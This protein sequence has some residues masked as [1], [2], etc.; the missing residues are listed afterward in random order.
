M[1]QS[2][3]ASWI[4]TIANTAAGFGLSLFLQWVYFDWWLGFPLHI[5]DN[6]VF[7]VIMTIVSLARG[8]T[9]RR[10]FEA[11]HIR[12]PLSPFMQ[13]VIAERVRQ[14]EQEG[15][16]VEHDNA[17]DAGT[18]AHAGASYALQADIWEKFPDTVRSAPPLCPGSWPWARSWWKP[19]EFRRDLVKAAALIIA[20]GERH[21]RLKTKGRA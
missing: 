3:L 2:R 16:S 12:R 5:A 14:I 13:A 17:H 4:E 1:K 20:D 21:D 7:A 18:L 10:I 8:F 19:T 6:L 9:M 11:L 15:W